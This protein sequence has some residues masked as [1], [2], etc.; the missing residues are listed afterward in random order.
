MYKVFYGRLQ[1]GRE[2]FYE[3]KN[4]IWNQDVRIQRESIIQVI[5]EAVGRST[6][7]GCYIGECCADLDLSLQQ[8][9]K[10]DY[11]TKHSERAY[12]RTFDYTER[13]NWTIPA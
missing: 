2:I 11:F 8:L 9:I 12:Q 5:R 4:E 10:E 1:R 13:L 6:L 7:H 3:D